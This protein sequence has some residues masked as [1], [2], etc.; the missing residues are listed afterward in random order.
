MT[1]EI[2]INIENVLFFVLFVY[3]VYLL[4]FSYPLKEQ[5]IEGL[6]LSSLSNNITPSIK[7]QITTPIT[8]MPVT[9]QTP[10]STTTP[11]SNGIASNATGYSSNI[12]TKIKDLKDKLSIDQYKSDYE[13]LLQNMGTLQDLQTL[14]NI[15]DNGSLQKG[16]TSVDMIKTLDKY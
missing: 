3:C 1:I 10:I 4:F 13:D 7:T 12:K 15:F 9:T 2:D 5:N 14:N 8:T 16:Q 6:T 11:I